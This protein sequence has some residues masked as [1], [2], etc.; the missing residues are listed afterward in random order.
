LKDRRRLDGKAREDLLPRPS[1][2]ARASTLGLSAARRSKQDTEILG[3]FLN[4]RLALDADDPSL[5]CLYVI[6]KIRQSIWA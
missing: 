6:I 1:L 3:F 4:P 5:N 2:A